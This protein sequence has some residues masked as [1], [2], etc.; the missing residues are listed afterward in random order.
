[1]KLIICDDEAPAR[2]RLRYL[3]EEIGGYEIVAEVANGREAIHFCHDLAPD[4]I[5][6]DIRMPE[7]DGIETAMHLAQLE[8][9]GDA[10]RKASLEQSPA[11]IFT[12]AYDAHAL[13][14][15]E[16]QAVDY[17]LKPIRRDRLQQA[18]ARARRLNRAQIQ[19]LHQQEANT[20][21]SAARSHLCVRQGERLQLIAV[22]QVAYFQ[23]DQK[24]VTVR[25]SGGETLIEES[26]T[27]LEQEFA[28]TFLRIHRNALIAKQ[29][30]CGMEKTSAGQF[31]ALVD[32]LTERLDISRRH[33]AEVRQYLKQRH[34]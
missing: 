33:V 31:V 4:I 6:L 19:V 7:M 13:A 26:L 24:Y 8:Q 16:A 5:L 21:G 9:N 20:T 30:L 14:A 12:T 28:E 34:A 2:E 23:A 15:F 1:M 3:V 10:Q 25:H 22:Q 11:V 32:G 27:T 17:L 18:L 29:F